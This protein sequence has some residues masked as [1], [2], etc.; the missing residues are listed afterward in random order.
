M[1]A[2]LTATNLRVAIGAQEILN[3][4]NIELAEGEILAVL[5]ANGVGKTTLMRTL[6]GITRATAGAITFAGRD[7]TNAPS[8]R[9][10]AAGLCQ[11]PEG[12]QIFSA[13]TVRENLVLGGG[14]HG[15]GELD[16][17]L[18]PV[19]RA[20]RTPLPERRLALRRRTADAVHRPRPD[21]PPTRCCCSTSPRSAWRRGLCAPSSPSSP[22][23]GRRAS[24]SSL[25]EQN[26]RAALA[27]ADRAA[28][29]E[30][31]RIV[32]SGFAADLARDRRIAQAYLGGL[33]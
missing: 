17:V 30:G 5:G 13:M 20:R 26:A 7:I 6:S 14:R 28:V 27:V 25:V 15:L 1:T 9:I 19:P 29:M 2:I 10:V 8:H 16:S 4:I 21:A 33:G 31:G 11:A 23:S 3:G 22:A 18:R 32:L 12:R 24:P